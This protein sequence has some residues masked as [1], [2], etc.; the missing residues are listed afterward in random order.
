MLLQT[1]HCTSHHELDLTQFV[2]ICEVTILLVLDFIRSDTELP[3]TPLTKITCSNCSN[4]TI[5]MQMMTN[6]IA[7]YEQNYPSKAIQVFL[8]VHYVPFADFQ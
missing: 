1:Q 8:V 2:N 7:I 5:D 3:Y 6:V 4:I